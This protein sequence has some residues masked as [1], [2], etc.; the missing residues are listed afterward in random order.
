FLVPS[1]IWLISLASR[2]WGPGIAGWLSGFPIVSAP[3]LF[4][5]AIDQG[6]QFSAEA[7]VATLSAVFAVFVFS[8]AYAWTATRAGWL[9]SVSAG[10]LGY[11]SLVTLLSRLAPPLWVSAPLVYA[12]V[13]LAPRL[14]PS[15]QAMRKTPMFSRAEIVSRMAAGAVLVLA[16]TYFA[17]DLGPRWSGL[18]A[19]FPVLGTVLA[20]FSHRQAGAP[21]TINLLRGMTIGYYAFS[22]FCLVLALVLPDMSVA[23]AFTLALGAAALIQVFARRLVT[24]QTPTGIGR[25]PHR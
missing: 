12:M 20:V 25:F 6:P 9:A 16:L 23:A 5:L 18:L 8:L 22:T 10:L 19:M 4:F 14:F 15:M 17:R 24:V 1:L 21:F 3:V 2:R 7:A 11:F 13:A